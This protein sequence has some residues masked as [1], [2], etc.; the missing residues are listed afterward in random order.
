MKYKERSLPF[1]AE[2][3]HFSG[4]LSLKLLVIESVKKKNKN[5][6]MVLGADT[7]QNIFLENLPWLF[8]NS[9]VTGLDTK[10]L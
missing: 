7:L 9:L 6:N 1:W 8:A 5:K 4:N 2:T 10:G 3:C